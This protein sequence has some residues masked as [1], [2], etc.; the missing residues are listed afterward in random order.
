MNQFEF[1]RIFAKVAECLNFG[2]AARQPGISNAAVT[3]GL[4]ALEK[5]FDLRLINR[6]TDE[7]TS[8]G[9]AVAP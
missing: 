5:P 4:S 1:T 8:R 2:D 7:L 3:R 6:T 9:L